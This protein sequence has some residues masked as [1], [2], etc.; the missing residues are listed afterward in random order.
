ME[1][2]APEG[3]CKIVWQAGVPYTAPGERRDQNRDVF[4]TAGIN[5]IF[6]KRAFNCEVEDE[7][8][9]AIYVEVQSGNAHIK[10]LP[11]L[12][13][14]PTE[15]GV[16]TWI[17]FKKAPFPMAFAATRVVGG[18]LEMGTAHLALA[19]HCAEEGDITVHG[20]GELKKEGTTYFYNALSGTFTAA[21]T[22]SKRGEKAPRMCQKGDLLNYIPTVIEA[23]I[24]AN[25]PGAT[26]TAAAT[27]LVTDKVVTKDEIAEYTAK[28][29]VIRTYASKDE[30]R[31]ANI[32]EEGGRRRK[33][34][35]R[36]RIRKTRKNKA[37]SRA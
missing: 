10:E 5:P 26:V 27:T 22:R 21:W 1:D 8:G 7:D 23:Y 20:A 12:S 36:R 33:T 19:A 24:R 34:R 28:G 11:T 35:R 16:Y 4:V 9:R 17:F 2:L 25:A 13:T 30:C 6:V 14:L 29:W 18:V 3:V 37:S 31:K 15:D 32:P